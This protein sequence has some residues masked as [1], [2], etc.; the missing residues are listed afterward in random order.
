MNLGRF[1]NKNDKPSFLPFHSGRDY[2]EQRPNVF[3]RVRG[4]VIKVSLKLLPQVVLGVVFLTDPPWWVESLKNYFSITLNNKAKV[5]LFL[6]ALIVTIIIVTRQIFHDMYLRQHFYLSEQ[7]TQVDYH[8]LKIKGFH[9]DG[10]QPDITVES[11][12][13]GLCDQIVLLFERRF[14]LKIFCCVRLAS[15][16]EANKMYVTVGR[17]SL[18]ASEDRPY[19]PVTTNDNI[20][21]VLNSNRYYR[22]VI[23]N[24]VGSSLDRHEY[25][26]NPRS[27]EE[28]VKKPKSMLI[29]GIYSNRYTIYNNDN[30]ENN[31][32]PSSNELLGLLYI[33]CEKKGVFDG[34]HIDFSRTIADSISLAV[35]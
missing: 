11:L 27:H 4:T 26:D 24:D 1:I 33:K 30:Q 32:N 14:N 8:L 35:R 16:D 22:V 17:S 31:I 21:T 2:W 28:H 6:S 25:P 5:G 23:Y 18:I 13:N 10:G 15:L 20:C 19:L 3:N 7:M 34:R 12:F 29:A 9:W